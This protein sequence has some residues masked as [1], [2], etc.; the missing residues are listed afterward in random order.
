M[1]SDAQR[2]SFRIKFWRPWLLSIIPLAV[3]AVALVV[4]LF[5]TGE[6]AAGGGILL[7]LA[8]IA[9][10][11]MAPIGLAARTSRWHVD[12]KG[13]GGRNNWLAYHRLEWQQI[14]SVDPWLIPG[15]P[16]LQVN[17]AGKRWVFWLPLFLTDMPG[18]RSAVLRY[19]APENPLRSYFEKHPA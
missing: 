17:G 4:I 7:G 18:L 14:E 5:A 10:A 2:L 6:L 3:L 19:A 12:P 16:Y 15:Y 1:E 11:L 13:I 9:V 8:G